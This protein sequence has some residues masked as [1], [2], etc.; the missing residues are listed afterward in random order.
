MAKNKSIKNVEKSMRVFRKM[1]ADPSKDINKIEK[2]I[3]I[4]SRAYRR[5]SKKL[6]RRGVN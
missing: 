4:N 3:W 5:L 2:D 1:S 6:K